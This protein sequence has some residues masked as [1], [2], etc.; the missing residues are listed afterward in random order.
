MRYGSHAVFGQKLLNIQHGV[1][2]Y[3]HKSPTMKW[4]NTLSLQ[5]NS[6]KLNAAS[7][8]NTSWYTDTGGF[9]EYSLSGGEVIPFFGGCP[10]VPLL[11]IPLLHVAT[12]APN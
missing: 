5:K 7:H 3:A 4:A 2:R 1:G 8:N 11:I 9:L 12:Q 6:L 10:L